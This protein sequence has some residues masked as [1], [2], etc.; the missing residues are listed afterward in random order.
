MFPLRW[1][2]GFQR[3][4][5]W[6]EELDVDMTSWGTVGAGGLRRVEFSACEFPFQLLSGNE[7][8]SE[9]HPLFF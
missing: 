8:L 4:R 6:E 9:V 2:G 1:F 5:R 3:T 7:P